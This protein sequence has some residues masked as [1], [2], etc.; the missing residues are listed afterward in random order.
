MTTSSY[1]YYVNHDPLESP[2]TYMYT[3]FH[4][5]DFID[6][7]F[8]SRK[9]MANTS[10]Q[11]L[12]PLSLDKIIAS[13]PLTDTPANPSYP[14]SILDCFLK[15]IT[16]RKNKNKFIEYYDLISKLIK[17]FEVK[18]RLYSTYDSHLVKGEGSCKIIDHYYLL[19]ECCLDCFVNHQRLKCLNTSLKLGDVLVA[20]F[21]SHSP[22]YLLPF[23]RQYL[24][25]EMEV[26]K[27]FI[28]DQKVHTHE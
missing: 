18:K 6:E 10:D 1:Q 17:R 3:Q 25:K 19:A 15:I 2:N 26:M 28:S 12:I 21:H 22:V 27:N 7:Y 9:S 8:S 11:T 24:I 4:G 5:K 16:L 14:I 20:T 23:I 13:L